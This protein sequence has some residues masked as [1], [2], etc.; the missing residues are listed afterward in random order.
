MAYKLLVVDDNKDIVDTLQRRLTKEG[1]EVSVAYDGE[2]ALQKVKEADP[3]IILLDLMMPKLNGFEVL[4]EV[5][6]KFKHKWRPIIIIS[7]RDELES[8]QKCYSMEADHY[9]TK[10]CSIENILQGIRTMISLLSAR[11]KD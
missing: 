1:Y 7:A 8:M 6:E 5:R 11:I 10:P 3:D 2:E 9:L 4:K